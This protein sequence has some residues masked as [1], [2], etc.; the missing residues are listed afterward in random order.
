MLNCQN[1][2]KRSITT[3]GKKNGFP[4]TT[5]MSYYH[6]SI[7]KI[8]TKNRHSLHNPPLRKKTRLALKTNFVLF[9]EELKNLS[10]PE[11]KKKKSVP[12]D[13]NFPKM[14]KST[15]EI[16]KK[17]TKKEHQISE[18]RLSITVSTPSLQ[19]ARVSE[20]KRARV[21]LVC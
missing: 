18:R 15:N 21:R 9:L 4:H 20:K 13:R 6:V 19:F 7:L 14:K 10:P 1:K 8:E 17:K 11:L 2:Q 5:E 12:D 16:R 3:A